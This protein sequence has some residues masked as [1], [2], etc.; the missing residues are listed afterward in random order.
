MDIGTA[1][2]SPGELSY[3]WFEATKLPTGTPECL[4]VIIAEGSNPGPTLWV[5]GGLHGDEVT[6]IAT[7]QDV[8]TDDLAATLTGNVVCMPILNPAGVRRNH[9]NSYYHEEDPNR[10]FPYGHADS[11]SP[12]GV[13]ELIDRR[14][15]DR[16]SA[17]ADALVSLHTGWISERPFT[18]L[19]RVRYGA[20][21]SRRSATGLANRSRELA[22]AFGLPIVNEYDVEIQEEY[23]LHR[24]FECAAI[25]TAGIP[26]IAPEL[27][28]P[29]V[30]SR[31][32][33][34]VGIEGVR[35][36]MRYL[37]MLPDEP[38]PNPEAP[39]SPVE[40][41]VKRVT[42]PISPTPGIV[43]HRIDAGDVIESGDPIADI[44]SPHGC[45]ETCVRSDMSG[46]ILGRREGVSVYENDLLVS[47]AAHDNGE[48]IVERE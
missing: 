48:L 38:T 2:S 39:D 16:F 15:F 36:V 47:M 20:D 12:P 22:E 28:G 29:Q 37:D 3:G 13:Q 10:F 1:S 14:I 40:F 44:V 34:E 23:G 18:I 45:V 30:V 26:A 25:N 24:S 33:R 17:T 8:M 42:G 4:P 11:E 35:N 19:E 21:R 9:R 7:A 46:Y 6:S 41:P 27:G 43:R 32:L 5:T 31:R